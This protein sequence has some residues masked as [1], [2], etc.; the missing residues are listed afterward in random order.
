MGP[1]VGFVTGSDFLMER[2]V[3]AAC[4]YGELAPDQ[5]QLWGAMNSSTGDCEVRRCPEI[6]SPPTFRPERTQY[7]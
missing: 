4:W 6:R 5:D 3:T 7:L 2:G 1:N